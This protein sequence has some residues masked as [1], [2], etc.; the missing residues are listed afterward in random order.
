MSKLRKAMEL[1]RAEGLEI[2]LRYCASYF[3]CRFLNNRPL[4]I[5]DIY[6][7]KWRR[8]N[9]VSVSALKAILAESVGIAYRP[10]I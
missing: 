8:K 1:F 10:L 6:Y 7:Q 5:E 2:A 9:S 4:S 3:A